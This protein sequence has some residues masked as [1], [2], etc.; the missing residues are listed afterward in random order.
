MVKDLPC[1]PTTKSV[2]TIKI[3]DSIFEEA[4]DHVVIGM[5]TLST[6]HVI[7]S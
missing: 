7:L 2:L 3:V 1:H 4:L 6:P 5:F